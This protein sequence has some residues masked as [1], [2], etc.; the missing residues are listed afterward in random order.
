MWRNIEGLSKTID[1]YLDESL[2]WDEN[3]EMLPLHLASTTGLLKIVFKVSSQLLDDVL[4][5]DLVSVVIEASLKH[6]D[7]SVV[8]ETVVVGVRVTEVRENKIK[9]TGLITSKNNKIFEVSFT[10]IIVSKDYLRR[11]AIEKTT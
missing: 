2:I 10:R 4:P 11:K 8:G 9:F 3:D 5:E 1:Y 6:F 7:T